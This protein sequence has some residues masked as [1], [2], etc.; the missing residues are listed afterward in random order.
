MNYNKQLFYKVLS[1]EDMDRIDQGV[2]PGT[3][4]SC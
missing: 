2:L 1:R 3:S 4:L